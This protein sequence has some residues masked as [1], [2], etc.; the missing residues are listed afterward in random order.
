VHLPQ[1][2]DGAVPSD[3]ALSDP[4]GEAEE[5]RLF[6]VAVTRARDQLYL[7]APLRLHQYR[8]ARDD[9]HG[10]ALLTR[11]LGPAQLA[12]CEVL[13]AA[14]P[15]PVIPRL[16]ALAQTIEHELDTLWGADDTAG[17]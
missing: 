10:Y 4:D 13:D 2:V 3:M 9:R 6:Y 16:A 15:E 7:Y 1:L 17:M 12:R 8:M 5:Q 11:F 14:P